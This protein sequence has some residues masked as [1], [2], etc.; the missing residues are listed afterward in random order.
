MYLEDWGTS[1]ASEFRGLGLGHHMH[2]TSVDMARTLGIQGRTFYFTNK[3]L[4]PLAP[5]LKLITFRE[6]IFDN[7]RDAN[8]NMIVPVKEF[9][10]RA[11]CGTNKIQDIFN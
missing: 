8:G 7:F 2:A 9:K 1:V 10:S 3:E 4:A 6:I 5:Q 11:F